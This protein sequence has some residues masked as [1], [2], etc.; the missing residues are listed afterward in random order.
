MIKSVDKFDIG[1]ESKNGL[2]TT[3]KFQWNLKYE[4]TMKMKGKLFLCV[5]VYMK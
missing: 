1:D 2:K 5:E 3:P 4:N